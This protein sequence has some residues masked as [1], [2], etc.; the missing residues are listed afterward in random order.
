[1]FTNR[2]PCIWIERLGLCRLGDMLGIN[3]FLPQLRIVTEVRW[4]TRLLSAFCFYVWFNIMIE[5]LVWVLLGTYIRLRLC[6]F[7]FTSIDSK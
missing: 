6:L 3:M 7:F 4:I 2:S 5:W 1:M